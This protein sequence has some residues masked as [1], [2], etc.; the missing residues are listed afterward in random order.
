MHGQ[1]TNERTNGRMVGAE[2]TRTVRPGFDNNHYG[3]SFVI[4]NIRLV[5]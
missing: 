3:S 5:V 2:P 4:L 1:R